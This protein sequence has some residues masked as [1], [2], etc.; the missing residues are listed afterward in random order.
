MTARLDHDNV[1]QYDMFFQVGQ[2][3]VKIECVSPDCD[4][5]VHRDEIL[6]RLSG[7]IKDK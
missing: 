2:G 1:Y 4:Q 3:I 5:F 7:P 6:A